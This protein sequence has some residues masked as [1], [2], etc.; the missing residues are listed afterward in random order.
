MG[1]SHLFTS[2]K[3]NKK[4]PRGT[5]ANVLQKEESRLFSAGPVQ[6]SFCSQLYLTAQVASLSQIIKR[7]SREKE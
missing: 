4:I 1:N 5:R 6:I 2:E 3:K 7:S